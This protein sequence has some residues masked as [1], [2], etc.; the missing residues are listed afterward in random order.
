VKY[1]KGDKFIIEIEAVSKGNTSRPYYTNIRAYL[2]DD[3]IKRIKK[4]EEPILTAE[5]AWEM[6]RRIY[7][8]KFIYRDAY[9]KNEVLEIFNTDDFDQI[10]T[11]N[12]V[13]E[14]DRKIKEW[15]KRKE[16][17]GIG[18]VVK[19]KDHNGMHGVVTKEILGMIYVLWSDGATSKEWPER[20]EKIGEV[21][22]IKEFL[23]Q[24][25][26]KEDDE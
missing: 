25:F 5:D 17:F 6:A 20:F 19:V 21:T 8:Q 23:E 3:D 22:G 4:Y 24:V 7:I 11:Q 15:K 14:A 1:K 2:G 18:D 12:T 26:G 9:S 10:L 13:F 16:E